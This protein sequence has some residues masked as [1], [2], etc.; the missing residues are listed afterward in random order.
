MVTLECSDFYLINC[1]VP[2]SGEGLKRL[3]YRLVCY[4]TC[5]LHNK[6][7]SHNTIVILH[8]LCICL[9]IKGAWDPYLR[10]YLKTLSETKPVIFT[11]T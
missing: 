4:L 5:L 1:Y 3:D 10:T 11:G 2:N 6:V 7:I 9:F 8:V